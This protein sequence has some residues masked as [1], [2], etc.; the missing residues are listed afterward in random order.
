MFN[1]NYNTADNELACALLATYLDNLLLTQYKAK[2][3]NYETK[4]ERG[5]FDGAKDT[6]ALSDNWDSCMAELGLEPSDRV[7]LTVENVSELL[8]E[9]GADVTLLLDLA[10]EK[11]EAKVQKRVAVVSTTSQEVSAVRELNRTQSKVAA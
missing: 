5:D 4:V 3:A 11:V 9:K 1:K 8:L 2:P 7:W 6:F 10:E